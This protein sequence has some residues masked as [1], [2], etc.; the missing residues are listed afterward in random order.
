MITRLILTAILLSMI[1]GLGYAASLTKISGTASF[2]VSF[3]QPREV[4][5]APM[6]AEAVLP[7]TRK[8]K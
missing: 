5:V 8:G 2:Q 3:N 4:M 7:T 6:L 1:A